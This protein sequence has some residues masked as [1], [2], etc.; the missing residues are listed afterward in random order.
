MVWCL[1]YGQEYYEYLEAGLK[2]IEY[3]GSFV[4]ME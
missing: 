2:V 3:R 1:I 4:R